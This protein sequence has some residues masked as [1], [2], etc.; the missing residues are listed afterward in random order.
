MQN[1]KPWHVK[2]AVIAELGCCH[3]ETLTTRH[4][5][6]CFEMKTWSCVAGILPAVAVSVK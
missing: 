4:P 6:A 5:Q 1:R 3:L 2:D